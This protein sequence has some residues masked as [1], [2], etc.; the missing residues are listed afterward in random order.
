MNLFTRLFLK[1]IKLLILYLTLAGYVC[2][3]HTKIN[4]IRTKNYAPF[5][6]FEIRTLLRRIRGLVNPCARTESVGELAT[7]GLRNLNYILEFYKNGYNAQTCHWKAKTIQHWLEVPT[8][9]DIHFK[10]IFI[11]SLWS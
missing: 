9:I 4:L 7:F 10:R 5:L 8:S 1:N 3:S 2:A 6:K 11:T